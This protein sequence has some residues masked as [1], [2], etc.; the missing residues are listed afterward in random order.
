MKKYIA[1]LLLATLVAAFA[2]PAQATTTASATYVAGA[3][4]A[5][6][7]HPNDSVPRLGVGGYTFPLKTTRPTK[8]HVADTDGLTS[9]DVL[10][11]Q[12]ANDFQGF[13]TNGSGDITLPATTVATKVLSVYVFPA[14][15]GQF[16]NEATCDG[17][18][19]AGT[20]TVTYA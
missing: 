7:P 19:T 1:P 15:T 2:G 16:I 14:S 11:S 6:V 8:V 4:G 3:Q 18:A 5:N 17:I 9:I 13:C 10:I 12:G 20:I